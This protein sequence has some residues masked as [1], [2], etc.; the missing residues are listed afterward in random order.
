MKTQYC[1]VTSYLG[2]LLSTAMLSVATVKAQTSTPI[3]VTVENFI[4]AE[5]D[6]Y[7][8]IPIERTP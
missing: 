3:P 8:V 2:I 6:L 4:R 1:K 5:S 7:F